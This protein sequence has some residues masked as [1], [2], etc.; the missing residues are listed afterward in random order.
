M[1]AFAVPD[2]NTTGS[3]VERPKPEAGDGQILVR[4]RAAGVNA[5]DPVLITGAMRQMVEHRLPLIPGFD[6]AGT[7]EAVGPG[8]DG[9]H[10]GDE[11]YG[12]V[13][14]PVM[15]E[16][17]WAEY[18]VASAALARPRL[19]GL[20]ATDAAALPLAG[21][22]AI[23]L[24]EA[25]DLKAGDTVLVVGAAG[26]VGSFLVQLAA[27]SGATLLAV[28]RASNADYVR[29]LG[30]AE[31]FEAGPGLVAL[32]RASHPDGVTAVIDTFHDA[33]GLRDIAPLVRSGGWIVSP[34]AYGGAEVLADFPI[35]FAMVSAALGRVGEVGE[36]VARG[37]VRVA[38]EV[39]GLDDGARA[40]ESM[41]SA[42]VRGKLVIS[43]E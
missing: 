41:A 31:V 22:A 18:V 11:V 34:K 9:L 26:G 23:A 20:S 2:F 28:T 25:V 37:D 27:R 24:L 35:S 5:V 16:G 4:V 7:V 19:V 38:V 32:V 8:V 33:Q 6:Y 21:G 1:R 13:G 43:L 36:L 15:G 39:V 12:A 29:G 3:V 14:A 30:A 42:G 40:L 10:V 17:S